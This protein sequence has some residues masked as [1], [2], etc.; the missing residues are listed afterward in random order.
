[1]YTQ[2]NSNY[3]NTRGRAENTYLGFFVQYENTNPKSFYEIVEASTLSDVQR[4]R[5]IRHE[6]VSLQIV[7]VKFIPR[8]PGAYF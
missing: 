1:M 7:V 3:S 6:T 2:W 4:I 8:R 5:R